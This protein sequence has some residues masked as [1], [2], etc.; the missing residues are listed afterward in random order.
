MFQGY[1]AQIVKDRVWGTPP[2]QRDVR[3]RLGM[4]RAEKGVL[5]AWFKAR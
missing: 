5:A 3:A 1:R 4:H 2:L